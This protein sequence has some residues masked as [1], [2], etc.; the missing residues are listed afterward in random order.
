MSSLQEVIHIAKALAVPLHIS[1]LKCIGKR[2]WGTGVTNALRLLNDARAAGMDITWDAYP[3]TAG[4]TQLVQ[5]LPP[6]YLA[7]G[8]AGI[9]AAL[10]D[11]AK[12]ATLQKILEEPSD[13]FENLV[14]LVGWDKIVLSTLHLPENQ[15]YVGKTVTEI[16]DMQGKTPFDCACDLLIAEQCKIAM[17]DHITA[18][19]DIKMIL[20]TPQCSV[21]SDSVYPCGG[22]PHPRLYGTFPRILAKYVRAE[23]ALTIEAAIHK[24]TAQPAAVYGLSK[25][26]LQVG[27]DADINVF[28]LAAIETKATYTQPKQYATGFSAVL[29]GGRLAVENDAYTGLCAGK[30]LL[31]GD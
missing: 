13:T 22:V 14:N 12:R 31:R 19:S 28:D 30:M 23:K 27:Q 3:Y 26:L 6:Q 15:K 16:A 8:T 11:G 20:Q 24:M 9:V 5:I 4:S 29:V 25:G 2:N 7:G 1:H 21:I 10:S 17:V 18:E